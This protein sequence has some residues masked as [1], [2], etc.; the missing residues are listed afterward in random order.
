MFVVVPSAWADY[1][2]RRSLGAIR[3][4]TL[5]AQTGGAAIGPVLTGGLYDILGDYRI[6]FA[7]LALACL[8]GAI[9]AGSA[10]RPR[11][12]HNATDA[13]LVPSSS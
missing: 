13:S 6:A 3:G 10:S 11:L 12:P 9:M 4:V 5:T 1:Y 2:G 8:A 7:A